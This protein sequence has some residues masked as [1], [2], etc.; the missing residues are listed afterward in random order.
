MLI[1][2]WFESLKE[3][4]NLEDLRIDVSLGNRVGRCGLDAS[5][6]GQ[7]AILYSCEHGNEYSGSINSGKFLD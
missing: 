7:G 6:S 2:L 5:A 1:I 4:D 3:R